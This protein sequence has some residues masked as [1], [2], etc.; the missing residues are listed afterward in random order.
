MRDH[1]GPVTVLSTWVR[2]YFSSSH[3]IIL[4]INLR[5]SYL[6]NR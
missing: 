4:R 6:F 5:S 2:Q 1:K 3:A